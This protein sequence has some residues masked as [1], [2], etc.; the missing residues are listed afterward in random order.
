[1][2]KTPLTAME[3]RSMYFYDI[4]SL[5]ARLIAGPLPERESLPYLVVLSR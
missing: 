1:M 3:M 4:T 2:W 5:K